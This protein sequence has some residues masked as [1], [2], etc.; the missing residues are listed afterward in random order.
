MFGRSAEGCGKGQGC[1]FYRTQPREDDGILP[2][3][4]D[5]QTVHL[6]V[7]QWNLS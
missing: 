1:G 7:S 4:Y 2:S 5:S 3:E 6:S